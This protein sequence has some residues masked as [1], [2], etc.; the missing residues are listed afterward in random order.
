MTKKKP[1][2]YIS[3]RNRPGWK[4][5]KGERV[6]IGRFSVSERLGFTIVLIFAIALVLF[7]VL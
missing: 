3:R 1:G 7:A 2:T 5:E 4:P 6:E